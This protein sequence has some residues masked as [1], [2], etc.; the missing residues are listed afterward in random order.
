MLNVEEN[1]QGVGFDLEASLHIFS[2]PEQMISE[3]V[4]PAEATLDG[5]EKLVGLQEVKE[6]CIDHA[7]HELGD[8]IE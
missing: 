6:P 2:E 3:T 4:S 7:L 8:D 5:S 1:R